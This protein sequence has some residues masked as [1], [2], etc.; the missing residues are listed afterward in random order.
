MKDTTVLAK[1]VAA[2]TGA[3]DFQESDHLVLHFREVRRAGEGVVIVDRAAGETT[4][5]TVS[6]E[7]HVTRPAG[8]AE[9][10]EPGCFEQWSPRG[11]CRG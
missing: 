1:I 9:P 11:H 6:T 3:V 10:T 2:I 4:V 5:I 8:F 7:R